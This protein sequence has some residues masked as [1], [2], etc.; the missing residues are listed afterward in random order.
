MKREKKNHAKSQ[1]AFVIAGH[2]H[3]VQA[4][5]LYDVVKHMNGPSCVFP[6]LWDFVKKIGLILLLAQFPSYIPTD[7]ILLFLVPETI[8]RFSF[9]LAWRGS[10]RQTGQ[11]K[12]FAVFRRPSKGAAKRAD[13]RL[14][15]RSPAPRDQR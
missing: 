6:R 5:I 15:R 14:S 13:Q 1:H 10:E 12:K 4:F 7:T 9:F 2:E 11:K 3:D 8:N